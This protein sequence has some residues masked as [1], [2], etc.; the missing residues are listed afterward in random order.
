MSTWI[1]FK[2]LRLKLR[3]SDV[4]RHYKVQMTVKG[5]RATGFCPL[6]THQ[7]Q[8]KS[9]SFSVHLERGIWQ[10]F[11]CQAKGNI[12]DFAC[13]MEGFNPDDPK[14]LRSAAL[15][16]RDIFQIGSEAPEQPK[17]RAQHPS[18]QILI[19]API[20]F[21]LRTLDPGHP[22]LKER[23]FTDE[24]I[25]H[26]GLGYCN[27]GMLKGR[28]AIPLHDPQGR[29]VGYAGRITK[30]EMVS[31]KCPKYLL[32]GERERNGAKLEF[33]KS[34]L[35]YNAHQIKAPV[36]HL[37]LVEGFPATWWLS[38][39]KYVNTVALMGAS[40]SEEQAKLIIDLVKPDGKVWLMPDGDEAAM[41]CAKS[42]LGQVSPHRFIRWVPLAQGTQPTD[43]SPDELVEL[44]GA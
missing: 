1:D 23:G 9:P 7:G 25:R 35:L 28:I 2:E 12:L 10:C 34:L 6:P 13:R 44:F 30:D 42:V 11:G 33:R 43:H 22:Y 39:A 27:R 26:F 40:C 4:F 37:F 20:D 3:F 15:K 41:Q 18:Q 16:I 8:R 21:E 38:Q 17:K 24:T 32:P 19:N 14:E 29:L 36:D 5:E 31:A